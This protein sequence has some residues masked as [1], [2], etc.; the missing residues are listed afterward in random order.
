MKMPHERKDHRVSIRIT[1][2]LTVHKLTHAAAEAL[3]IILLKYRNSKK[4]ILRYRKFA[5]F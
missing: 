2:R 3:N 4:H 1:Q 5:R